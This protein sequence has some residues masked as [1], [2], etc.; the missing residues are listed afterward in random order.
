MA[1]LSPLLRASQGVSWA[2]FLSGVQLWKSLFQSSFKLLAQFVSLWA[3]GWRLTSGPRTSPVPRGHPSFLFTWISTWLLI[4]SGQHGE[5]L[6][7]VC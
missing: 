2:A 5:F 1:K 7:P 6:A 3:V 4:S